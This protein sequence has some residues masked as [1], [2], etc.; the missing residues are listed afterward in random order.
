LAAILTIVSVVATSAAELPDLASVAPDLVAPAM[1]EHTPA[2]GLRARQTLPGWENSAV[3]HTLYLP[4]NWQP[5]GKFPVIF[6]Y[7]GNGGY[8]NAF[9][10]VSTGV[11]E[12]CNLGYGISGGSNFIWVCLPF[13][14]VNNGGP[15]VATRWWGDVD[16]TIRYATNAV[17]FVCERFGG[18]TNALILSG[19]SRGA[20]AGNFIGLHDERIA[21]LWRAFILHSHYDGVRAWPYEGSDRAAALKRLQ[22]LGGRPQFIS[23]EG[24]VE[25]TETYLRGTGVSGKFTFTAIPFRNHSDA[26]VLRDLPERRQVRAWLDT[27]LSNQ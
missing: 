19:F 21:P 4:A 6:E 8:S 2:P 20:I 22:R 10:D 9:G 14:A 18:D 3:Y 13:V 27:V 26:W 5:G 17:R 15:H 12:Q 23:Q 16:A 25:A 24:S 1:I 7:P 11:P